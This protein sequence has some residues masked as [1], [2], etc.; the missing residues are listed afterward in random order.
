MYF[1]LTW[2]DQEE[3]LKNNLWFIW[4]VSHLQD[5]YSIMSDYFLFV[6]VYLH[7]SSVQITFSFDQV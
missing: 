6:L 2:Q 4:I 3:Y 1:L 7:I 5:I